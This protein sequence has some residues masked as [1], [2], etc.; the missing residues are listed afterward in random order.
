MYFN[1]GTLQILLGALGNSNGGGPGP[2]TKNGYREPCV[3]INCKIIALQYHK[4]SE[5]HLQTIT[6]S[7]S[8]RAPKQW[9]LT[10]NETI[11]SYETWRQNLL[12]ILSLDDKFTPFLSASWKKK[13]AKTP[14][15]GL[16]DDGSTVPE[17][18]RLTATQK[19]RN[20]E[21]MLGQIANFYPGIARNS[22]LK[23]STSLDDVW[24]KIR[25]HLGFQR[26]GA[27]FLDLSYKQMND[28]KKCS[29]V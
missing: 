9:P 16:K 13:S 11:N 8:H 4:L 24:H 19:N 23:E 14:L 26:T 25:L 5:L 20:L 1:G 15:H 6:M 3:Y 28:Q 17:G 7:S 2:S 10:D 21:V 22:F 27:H 18:E 12:Y 29:N